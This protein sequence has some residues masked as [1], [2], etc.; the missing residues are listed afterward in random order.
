MDTVF[1]IP[2][3][4]WRFGLDPLLGLIPVVGDTLSSFV[5]LYILAIAS[6]QGVSRITLARMALNIAVDWL[7]GAVPFVGD[8]FDV[9]WKGNQRNVRLLR[10]RMA[11]TGPKRR[12][13]LGDWLFVVGI[14]TLLLLLLVDCLW[15]V[16][17]LLSFLIDPLLH[18]QSVTPVT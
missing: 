13:T 16:W 4:N 3:L 14:I 12:A 7:L 11:A 18:R 15:L 2:G 17:W 6:R 10:G 5:S 8:V 1:R 9:W